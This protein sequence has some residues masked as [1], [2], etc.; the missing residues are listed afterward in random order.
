MEAVAL[1]AVAKKG[2]VTLEHVK[3]EGIRDTGSS[4]S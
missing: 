4:E 2:M 1:E 3:L